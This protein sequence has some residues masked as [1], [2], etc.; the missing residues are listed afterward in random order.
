[1]Y[2]F[3]ILMRSEAMMLSC[4]HRTGDDRRNLMG[5]KVISISL[6]AAQSD[7]QLDVCHNPSYSQLMMVDTNSIDER[8]LSTKVS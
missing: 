1:M 7:A 3:V 6:A 4:V 8:Y 2:L 5:P